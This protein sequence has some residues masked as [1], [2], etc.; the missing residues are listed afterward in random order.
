MDECLHCRTSR[1]NFIKIAAGAAV[2]AT[3]GGRWLAP[4]LAQEASPKARAKSVILLFLQ[5]GPSQL[6]TFDPKPGTETG[7]PFQAI[8]SRLDGARLSELLPKLARSDKLSIVRTLHSNDPNHDTA[9]YLLHTGARVDSTIVHPHVGSL[10]ANELGVAPGG[11][12]G[13]ITIGPDAPAG[14]GY[15]APELAPLLVEKVENPLLDLTLPAGVNRYRLR[16]REAL[17]E[18]QD[19]QFAATHA[20]A[21]VEHQRAA[22]RRA[23]A[24]VRSNKLR[25]FDVTEE[26]ES[27][28]ELYGSGAFG[29]ACLMARRLVEEGVR[30]VEVTLADWDTHAD[31][32]NRTRALA[33][34]LDRGFAALLG[35]LESRGLLSETLVLCLGEFGRTPRVNAAQGR[36]HFTRAFAAALAGGGIAG[37]RAIGRTNELGT[38]TVERPVSV[39][40]LYATVYDRL[41]VDPKREFT[42]Q[43]GRPVKLLDGGTPVQELFA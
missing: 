39:Q 26:T 13:C 27:T 16:D 7:G 31:N 29:K 28:R 25:A 42:S 24:L 5:G 9:R 19:A 1:R 33:A 14:S 21:K 23:L 12:P 15:L 35:D 3:F 38:E 2:G 37:G 40:D 17:L 32:F 18:A 8:D 22:Y 43:T 30:C 34:E 4:L 6:D 36:D 41:G 10:I 11:L 20:E